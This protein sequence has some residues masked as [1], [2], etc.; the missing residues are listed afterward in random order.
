ME[1]DNLYSQ[2]LDSQLDG[3]GNP[4]FDLQHKHAKDP[5]AMDTEEHAQNAAESESDDEELIEDDL[6]ILMRAWVNERNAPDLLDYQGTAIENLMELVD[7]QTQKI[8][9]QPG[10]L[11]NILKMDVDR[12][13]YL[14]RS[15][16][17]ARLAKIEDHAAHYVRDDVYKERLSRSELEYAKGF[18]A[19]E[20]KH[21]RRSFLDQLPPHLRG[22]DETAGNGM[23]MVTKPDLDAAVFCR[24]R[25]NV[26]EFQFDASE[27][28][29]VM[30]RNNIFITR[31]SIIR[32][33]LEDGKVEL[34]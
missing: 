11:A 9:S 1:T 31:Y 32:N 7:F 25:S 19:L 12:V 13:K 22:L 30:K 4:G 23:D 24:V 17:R 29:I 21:M 33:L 15:Y 27:D 10:L 5:D 18:V 6:S 3:L 26:G 28:P 8:K 20:E 34:I 2:D 16:L 14:V